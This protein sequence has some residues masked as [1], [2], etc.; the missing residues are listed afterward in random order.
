MIHR[1]A[2]LTLD[3]R[4][5]HIWLGY[6][7]QRRLGCG[8]LADFIVLL[9]GLFDRITAEDGTSQVVDVNLDTV[10]RILAAGLHAADG[11]K[12]VHAGLSV[13]EVRAMID[14]E[15][16]TVDR[17]AQAVMRCAMAIDAAVTAGGILPPEQDADDD[18]KGATADADEAD[19]TRSRSRTGANRSSA[20]APA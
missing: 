14:A 4:P 20:P 8:R 7:T 1:S 2:P 18:K 13:D 12:L 16:A 6:A 11:E 10:E 15:S 9:I 3:G 19:P 17:P 5:L